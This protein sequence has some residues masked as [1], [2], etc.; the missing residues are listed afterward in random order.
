MKKLSRSELKSIIGGIST[1]Y[2]CQCMQ[3][4]CSNTPGEWTG[5]YCTSMEILN[6]INTYCNGAGGCTTY[7]GLC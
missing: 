5:S 1:S 6:D 3:C 4:K 7:A 2:D